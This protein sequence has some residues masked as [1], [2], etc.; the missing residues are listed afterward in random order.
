MASAYAPPELGRHDSSSLP[1]SDD[2]R[3]QHDEQAFA[4]PRLQSVQPAYDAVGQAADYSAGGAPRLV[5]PSEVY[6]EPAGG[7]GRGVDAYGAS[8]L[9][10]QPPQSEPLP[11]MLAPNDA[12]MADMV[13]TIESFSVVPALCAGCGPL[14]AVLVSSAMGGASWKSG[15]LSG[16][17]V[18][19]GLSTVTLY[20]SGA[21]GRVPQPLSLLCSDEGQSSACRLHSAGMVMRV[22]LTFA[23]LGAIASTISAAVLCLLDANRIAPLRAQIGAQGVQAL[24]RVASS[25]WAATTTLLGAA[26]LLYAALSPFRFRETTLVLDASY[27]LVR[28]AL[29]LSALCGL[30][31]GRYLAHVRPMVASGA[32]SAAAERGAMAERPL[33][34]ELGLE[35]VRAWRLLLER[36]RPLA[37]SLCAQLLLQLAALVHAP[38]WSALLV[39]AGACRRTRAACARVPRAPL[40]AA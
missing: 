15:V 30:V 2:E 7:Y 11:P 25:C 19:V 3:D 4:A 29:L 12:E 17:L 28:L 21:T 37:L 35:L 32:F 5:Q 23:L 31:H 40:R 24:P 14:I 27:G 38:Q 26:A 10:F 6:Q 13:S 22:L 20:G 34:V 18:T 1:N 9:A 39:F 33:E 16:E 8:S 36:S